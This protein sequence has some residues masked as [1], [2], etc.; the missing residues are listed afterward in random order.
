MTANFDSLS[1]SEPFGFLPNPLW[2]QT[3]TARQIKKKKFL[4]KTIRCF[5][6]TKNE[7]LLITIITITAIIIMNF[8]LHFTS[9]LELLEILMHASM[10]LCWWT[11]RFSK[12]R[13]QNVLPTNGCLD[14][15]VLGAHA[16]KQRGQ[17]IEATH[18][19]KI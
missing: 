3:T 5:L 13:R 4:S 18:F 17:D 2:N 15:T 11:D 19:Q 8:T 9:F 14:L 10:R 1:L 16:K 7:K 6:Y 12:N